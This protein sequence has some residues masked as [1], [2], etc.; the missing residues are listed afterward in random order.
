MDPRTLRGKNDISSKDW[1][2][3]FSC[4]K[5]ESA[6]GT[7]A[8][9]RVK[10][11]NV[12]MEHLERL[13]HRHW[14]V[15]QQEPNNY[16]I[17]LLFAKAFA[18]EN[19]TAAKQASTTEEKE[20]YTIAWAHFAE[21]VMQNAEAKQNISAKRK[22]WE[23]IQDL[24]TPTS[25]KT[26]VGM[27][28]THAGTAYMKAP[29]STEELQNIESMGSLANQAFLTT[30]EGVEKA[31]QDVDDACRDLHRAEGTLE[32][33]SSV[34]L[35]LESQ[36]KSMKSEEERAPLRKMLEELQPTVDIHNLR[37]KVDIFPR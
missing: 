31:H 29:Y 17:G 37:T 35:Y 10:C 36:M 28:G 22:K 5:P 7:G 11:Y 9:R 2:D 15:Y 16:E 23:E 21:E 6:Q 1:S 33:R 24:K 12:K 26:D 32:G 3:V 4:P 14:D 27:S 30:K 34:R 19:C 20:R 18:L 8:A 25:Y 13:I